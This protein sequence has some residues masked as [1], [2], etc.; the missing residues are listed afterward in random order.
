MRKLI[1]IE[2][3]SLDGVVQAPGHAAAVL[4]FEENS[5]SSSSTGSDRLAPEARDAAELI[6]VR[7]VE[8]CGDLLGPGGVGRTVTANEVIGPAGVNEQVRHLKRT[9]SAAFCGPATFSYL[10]E[11]TVLDSAQTYGPRLRELAD[12]AEALDHVLDALVFR[13]HGLD[14][15]DVLRVQSPRE[16]IPPGMAEAA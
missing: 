7:H 2:Y 12:R 5:R 16:P 8:D 6:D 11:R 10:C 4:Q 14:A 13:L 3:L 1:V 9:M 15:D